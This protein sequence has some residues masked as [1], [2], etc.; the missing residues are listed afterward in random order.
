MKFYF[1]LI[2]GSPILAGSNIVGVT[3]AVSLAAAVAAASSP[4]AAAAAV[5]AS[6]GGSVGFSAVVDGVVAA[7]SE[8][9]SL[10]QQNVEG[11][12]ILSAN[13]R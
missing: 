9:S 12:T 13:G 2:G 5:A 10:I 3:S 8:S 11:Q 4:L 1:F 6:A 7:N